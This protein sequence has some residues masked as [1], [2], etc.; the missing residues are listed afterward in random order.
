MVA[1]RSADAPP[2]KVLGAER[3][4]PK[5]NCE[6]HGLPG[7]GIRAS[8]PCQLLH[9]QLSQFAPAWVSA[10]VVFVVYRVRIIEGL[11]TNWAE[12]GAVGATE[13]RGGNRQHGRVVGPAAEVELVVDHVGAEQLLVLGVFLSHLARVDLGL[14]RGV[15]QAAPAGSL[16]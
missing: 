10:R 1:V 4:R 15:L 16:D 14:E 8:F 12:A 5:A 9:L 3:L 11:A 2:R 7:R 6:T 13:A